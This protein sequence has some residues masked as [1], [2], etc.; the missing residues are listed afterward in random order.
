MHILFSTVDNSSVQT[1]HF[2]PRFQSICYR[3]HLRDTTAQKID[4]P[5]LLCILRFSAS[6]FS[7][8]KLLLWPAVQKN[9]RLY[10]IR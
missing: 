2:F 6:A 5:K 10:M 1:M 7:N 9:M 4:Q 3:F 8:I